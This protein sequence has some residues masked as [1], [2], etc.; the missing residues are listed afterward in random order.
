MTPEVRIHMNEYGDRPE[1][2]VNERERFAEEAKLAIVFIEKW[3]LILGEDNGEDSAG[4]QR[5]RSSTPE[6]VVERAFAMARLAMQTARDRG[7]T[8]ALPT[9]AETDAVQAAHKA[10]KEAKRNAKATA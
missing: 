5:V 10:E 4:R 9:F 2:Q 7:L 8:Y 1:V 6:E 3:G